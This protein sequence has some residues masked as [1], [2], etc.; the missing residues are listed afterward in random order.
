MSLCPQLTWVD[1]GL[2]G[3][4][5]DVLGALL[6][7]VR[8]TNLASQWLASHIFS[9]IIGKIY[10]QVGGWLHVLTEGRE[11]D[12][13]GSR[14]DFD[15]VVK[16]MEQ[17]PPEYSKG[18]LRKDSRSY[19]EQIGDKEVEKLISGDPGDYDQVPDDVH[20]TLIVAVTTD[21][22]ELVTDSIAS[23][24]NKL[25]ARRQRI[26]TVRNRLE[27]SAVYVPA[28]VLATGFFLQLIGYVGRNYSALQSIGCPI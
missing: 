2:V 24:E 6:L 28:G 5:L 4:I 23:Y 10:P 7:A 19:A 1:V 26:N 22:D 12:L 8:E 16:M 9:P 14:M 13:S 25:H 17:D 11:L 27:D 18:N 15:G 20:S 21:G 3:L